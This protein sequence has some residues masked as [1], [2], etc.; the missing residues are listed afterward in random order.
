M[1][2]CNI[3]LILMIILFPINC[4]GLQFPSINSKSVIVYD[5]T[6]KKLLY[7]YNNDQV[8]SIASLTKIVTTIVAI[9]KINNLDDVVVISPEI[10]NSVDPV[11]SKAGLRVGD[12]V[13]YRDLLYASILPSGADATNALAILLSGSIDNFVNEMNLLVSKLELKN[14]HFVNVTGLDDDN[15]YSTVDDILIILNYA[16]DN[17]LF[18]DIFTTKK[19]TLSNGLDVYSTLYKYNGGD[20]LEIKGSKTGFTGNAGYCI[21]TLSQTDDHE[22]VIILLDAEHIDNLYYNIVD[23]V[24][25]INF[26]NSNFSNVLLQK[27]NTNLKTLSV[28]L[29]DID[30]YDI[31]SS[32]DIYKFLPSDFDSSLFRY[33]YNGLDKL[34]YNNKKGDK[35]GEISYYYDNDIIFKEDV[36]LT[37]DFNINYVKFIKKYWIYELVGFLVFLNIILILIIFI[38]RK[39]NERKNIEI[40]C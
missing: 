9:E 15:H 29:S 14:T 33:E 38:R 12:S 26:I 24:E 21:S 32:T 27:K 22:I 40:S 39:I 8:K 17:N 37:T 10:I 2:K 31:V 13:S 25:L 19:Y 3:F 23:S 20:I 11:A 36:I 18:Y 34:N 1:K 28:D 4:F 35:I 16:L 6:D 30:S 7:S 5:R